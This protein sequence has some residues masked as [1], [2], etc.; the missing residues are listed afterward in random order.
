VSE[1]GAAAWEVA[2]SGAG[3]SRGGAGRLAGTGTDDDGPVDGGPPGVEGGWKLCGE[4]AGAIGGAPATGSCIAGGAGG[5]VSSDAGSAGEAA[6]AD[7][8]PRI[9]ATESKAK[10]PH[11][12]SEVLLITP[13]AS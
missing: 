10:K 13:G 2:L 12:A 7:S 1:A 3:G 9:E 6:A 11:Q 8:C 4:A 5:W